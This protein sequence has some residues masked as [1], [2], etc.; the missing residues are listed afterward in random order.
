MKKPVLPSDV[1]FIIDTL[2]KKGYEAYIVGGCVRDCILDRVPQDWDI[3]TSATPLEIKACFDH[4]YDTGIQH[5]TV[6]AVLHHCNYEITTYRI[7]GEYEDYRRPS[8]VFFTTNLQEDL[9]RRDFTMNAIAYHVN[10]GFQDPFC[11]IEDIEKGIIRGV[12]NAEKRFEEDALRMLRGVR[13]SAQ[14]GFEIEK[15]TYEA[16]CKNTP[17]IEKI[18]AERIREELQKLI[19]A[20]F[21][22]KIPLVWETGLMDYIDTVWSQVLK[23]NEIQLLESLEQIEKNPILCWTLFVYKLGTDQ[24]QKVL[25][26]LKF[27]TKSMRMIILLTEALSLEITQEDYSIKKAVSQLG[28][29][30]TYLLLKL[31]A[32]LEKRDTIKKIQE[33]LD[34][35]LKRKDCLFLKDLCVKG[36]DLTE[37]GVEKG[38]QI[39]FILNELLDIV[40]RNPELNTKDYLCKWIKEN[41]IESL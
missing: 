1:I 3:T 34:V 27:D 21:I 32:V 25:K 36:N 6:T 28:I 30:E 41:Y 38:K 16:L 5:G 31:K 13:F 33:K 19:T 11:G 22:Q 2:N 23:Q 10:T 29:E 8:E 18:S 20:P 35:I 40:H 24:I 7:E 17:L 14:L 9:L 12:G 37:L 4:T 15:K 26:K 39:G